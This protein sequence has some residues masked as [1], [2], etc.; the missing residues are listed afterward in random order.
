MRAAAIVALLALIPSAAAQQQAPT[1]VKRADL[2]V[3]LAEKFQE[4]LIASG[5]ADNGSLLELFATI[6]G[7]TWTVALTMPNGT[8][9]LVATGNTWAPQAH[10]LPGRA[11]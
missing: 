7:D 6:D 9:C 2:V 3:H 1:C 11:L 4:A 5:V 10:R 8:A